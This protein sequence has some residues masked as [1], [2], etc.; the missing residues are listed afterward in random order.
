MDWQIRLD[1]KD[2]QVYNNSRKVIKNM[3]SG[4]QK[5]GNAFALLLLL[6]GIWCFVA[7]FFGIG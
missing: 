2:Q 6:F 4:N 7:F 3:E 1:K 5:F